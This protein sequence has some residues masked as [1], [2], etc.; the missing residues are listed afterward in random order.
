MLI[1]SKLLMLIAAIGLLRCS[2][3]FRSMSREVDEQAMA[4]LKRIMRATEDAGYHPHLFPLLML[5]T[6]LC[7]L[8]SIYLTTAAVP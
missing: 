1:I 2:V 7:F 5:L 6:A 3:K 4:A 8:L